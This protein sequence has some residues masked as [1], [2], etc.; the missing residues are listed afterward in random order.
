MSRVHKSCLSY[1]MAMTVPLVSFVLF[2]CLLSFHFVSWCQSFCLHNTKS[3]S[4]HNVSSPSFLSREQS[5][6]I[7]IRLCAL[8]FKAYDADG[9]G[10]TRVLSSR[11]CHLQ[12][13][14]LRLISE[15][16]EHQNRTHSRKQL[17]GPP[18]WGPMI[19]LEVPG[20]NETF[21][22]EQATFER[23]VTSRTGKQP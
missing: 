9:G 5:E 16:K 4:V 7:L 22:G 15:W 19:C 2:R 12:V 13:E 11:P 23:R 6:E 8:T 1:A 20:K 18:A 10:S 3:T 21:E 17:H 14:A